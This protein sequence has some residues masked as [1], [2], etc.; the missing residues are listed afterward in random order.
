MCPSFLAGPEIGSTDQPQ[1]NAAEPARILGVERSL[2]GRRWL[3]RPVDQRAVQALVQRWELSELTARVLAGRGVALEEVPGFLAPTLRDLLPDPDRFLDMAQG[4]ERL[5]GAVMQGECIGI[6]GDYDVDGATSSALLS[7]FIRAAGGR[8]AIHIPDRIKEGYGPNTPAILG[9]KDNHGASVVVTVDCG[10]LAFEPVAAARDAG[11]DVI[12]VDHH[13]AEADLPRAEAVINPNRLDETAGHGQLAA[14]GVTFL[15]IVAV[16]RVLRGAGWYATRSEP[17]LLQWLDMVALGTVCDV[18]PL[19]GINRA[20]VIQGLKVL[21][22]RRNPG[23]R[24]LAD[25]AGV[26]ETPTAYHLGFVLGP[27]VNAGGRVGESDL[28]YRLMTTEHADEAWHL[29]RRLDAFNR[30]RQAIEGEVLA[31]AMAQ[32]EDAGG[33]SA[34]A[35]GAV[36][37][38]HGDGWHPGVIGIV[39]ARLKER[40]NRPA[41]VISFNGGGDGDLGVGSGRSVKGVDLGAA[42]IAARQAGLIE[43]GGGHA[44][45]AGFTV[46]RD[47]LAAFRQFLDARVAAHMAESGIRPTLY[48]DGALRPDAATEDLVEE[49]AKLGPFGAGNPEPRFVMPHA[50]LTYA[51]RVGENHVKCAVAKDAR[52]VV[53]GIAF[54]ALDS[55]LG[56]ALL[57]HDGRLLHLAG[58]LRFN[59]WNGRTTVQF[60]IE[61]AQPASG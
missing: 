5:A 4:A 58:R 60:Q 43:K 56:A 2:T 32:L 17:D 35:M 42:I 36:A 19:T 44:M 3:E 53:E 22:A 34:N 47:K 21:A 1:D 20:L 39:A 12:V 45:A 51:D 13:T 40:Y 6:F 33:A 38:A 25:V 52:G 23:L 54:R 27:R 9:L 41:C 46:A 59:S 18:V 11:I 37:L 30:E 61:D 55:D 49:I 8:T 16:N 24:A 15:L 10:T 29:A 57:N 14:V 50:R 26:D 31:G 28:G 7:R 48:L